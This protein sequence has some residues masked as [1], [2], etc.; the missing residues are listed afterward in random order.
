MYCMIAKIAGRD[1]SSYVKTVAFRLLNLE[2][3]NTIDV[4][5]NELS[6]LMQEGK[7]EVLNLK[8]KNGKFQA[9]PTSLALY[10]FANTDCK[11]KDN[12]TLYAWIDNISYYV[13][14]KDGQVR[15]LNLK[16]FKTLLE[17]SKLCNVS[18]AVLKNMDSI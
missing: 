4:E 2:S 10:P 7:I 13:S 18:K 9:T 5:I 8:Y 17:S 3:L 16:Q 11:T 1:Y 12:L 6:K 14:D 15:V